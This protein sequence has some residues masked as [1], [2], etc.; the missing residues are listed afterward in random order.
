MIENLAQLKKYFQNGGAIKM[1]WN[2]FDS[3]GKLI[4]VIRKPIK[5]QT[6]AIK[7]EGGSWL[8]YDKASNYDFRE[9]GF[10]VFEFTDFNSET[11]RHESEVKRIKIISYEYIN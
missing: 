11:N 1:T 8:Q 5:V 6:N 2:Q 9:T 7:F 10:D 3:K 4:D